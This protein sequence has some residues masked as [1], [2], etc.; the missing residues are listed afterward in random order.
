MLR[1]FVHE[2]L[3]AGA[4]AV[5]AG[6]D[7]E[8]LAA[9]VA[10]R[11]A[12]V[13]DLSRLD[14]VAVTCAI[15]PGA[16]AAA[17]WR[18]ANVSTAQARPGEPPQAF[19][20]RMA[21][22]HELSWIVA[23]ETG[24]ELARL[25]AAVGAERWIGCDAA[26]IR[27]ASS[28]RATLAVLAAAGVPTPLARAASHAGRW[29]VKPDDGAGCLGTR[30]HADRA[31][32][33]AAAALRR[34]RGDLVVLE[35]FVEGEALSVSLLV[36]ADLAEAVSFNRQGIAADAAG[37][38]SDLGVRPGALDAAGDPRIPRL[39]AVAV[40]AVRALPGL[41]GFVGID[42][43]WNDE[44][45]AVVI[46]INPRVT[47]AYVGSSARLGRNLAADILRLKGVRATSRVSRDGVRA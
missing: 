44:R 15:G 11:D 6:A 14:G 16:G 33:Q 12:I 47:C 31:A 5:P 1:I 22:V 30:V 2:S 35:P 26:A 37:F 17:A 8:L 28:K 32:A 20:A 45:G 38:L 10:M 9:G 13:H 24:G 34:V 21:A 18:G 39:E 43:V 19:V 25:H 23:P 40:A 27:C 42:L 7:R 36:G 46:E 29:L 3:S 4:A 41:G